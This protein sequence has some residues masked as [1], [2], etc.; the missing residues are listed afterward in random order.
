MPSKAL[1]ESANRNLT[2]RRAAEFGLQANPGAPDPRF[3]AERNVYMSAAL[4]L[5]AIDDRVGDAEFI[6]LLRDWAQDHR[7]RNGDRAM[8]TA[9]ANQH[10]GQDLTGLINAWLDEPALGV[11]KIVTNIELQTIKE[12]AGFPTLNER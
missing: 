5:Q 11:E 6:A 2:L 9:F 8:F 12:F 4:L 7:G 10:T 1:I 3:F